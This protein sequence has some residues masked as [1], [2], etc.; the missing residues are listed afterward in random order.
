MGF[1][2]VLLTLPVMA[3]DVKDG[4]VYYRNHDY[5]KAAAI[6]GP[7]AQKG[8]A[9]A[10]TLLAIMYKNGNGLAKNDEK[11]AQLYQLAA[12]QGVATA[13][14]DLAQMYLNGE[15]ISMDLQKAATMFQKAAEQGLT[16]AQFNLGL[17][18]EDGKVIGQNIDKAIYWYRK[19][20][21]KIPTSGDTSANAAEEFSEASAYSLGMIYKYGRGV[22]EDLL[23]ARYWFDIAAKKNLAPAEYQLGLLKET[24]I[25]DEKPDLQHSL[26]WY[27][28]AAGHGSL[29]AKT[30][31]TAIKTG[32][33]PSCTNE[34]INELENNALYDFPLKSGSWKVQ[35]SMVSNHITSSIAEKKS[36]QAEKVVC[37]TESTKLAPGEYW[38]KFK[39]QNIPP[40]GSVIFSETNTD[41]LSAVSYQSIEPLW[42]IRATR[43]KVSDDHFEYKFRYQTD[44]PWKPEA[45]TSGDLRV[46]KDAKYTGACK[47]S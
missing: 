41:R 5:A 4:F 34:E 31:L 6:L 44:S 35:V 13:Q 36:C 42:S 10:E 46:F 45:T 30:Q 23:K 12:E 7:A 2:F 28:K 11:A 16:V 19:A 32:S 40:V 37:V 43:T 39:I 17:M 20:A 9:R 27:Q 1:I 15:G 14:Y 3:D 33:Q 8:D 21:E 26:A 29:L 24:G 25:S 47:K 18:Y 38:N 22:T